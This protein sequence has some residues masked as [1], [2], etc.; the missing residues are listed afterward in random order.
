MSQAYTVCVQCFVFRCKFTQMPHVILSVHTRTRPLYMRCED[1]SLKKREGP[2]EISQVRL[3]VLVF[4]R[5]C[6]YGTNLFFNRDRS[7]AGIH[8]QTLTAQYQT[9]VI[10]VTCRAMLSNQTIQIAVFIGQ[11][12][13][14]LLL[15]Y[16]VLIVL[17]YQYYHT[18]FCGFVLLYVTQ[19][20]RWEGVR[21][22]E[23]TLT[24]W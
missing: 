22:E 10:K 23:T 4:F 5:S 3:Y 15:I 18:F 6:G 11:T 21:E 1:S 13:T 20:G 2:L 9:A 7:C 24:I 8:I 19:E 12:R 16:L 17:N 14:L